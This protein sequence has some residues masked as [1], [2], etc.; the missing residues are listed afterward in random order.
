[1]DSPQLEVLLLGGLPIREPIAHYGPFL[2]N[3]RDEVLTAIEDFNAGRM[4][5]IPATNLG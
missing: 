2:M 4:G 1:E 5:R 3:T